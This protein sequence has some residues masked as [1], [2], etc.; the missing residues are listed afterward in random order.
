[1]TY[2]WWLALGL[3]LLTFALAVAL[4]R[5]WGELSALKKRFAPIVYVD[6]ER[7]RVKAETEELEKEVAR[8]RRDW[9]TEFK[10]TIAELETLTSELDQ[11]R[12]LVEMQ[13]FGV[14]EPQFDFDTPERYK[15]KIREIRDEQKR[16]VRDKSA[17]ICQIEW[18]VDGSKAKGRTMTNRHLRLMLRA[19]NGEC[20]AA[21][22]KARYSNVVAL[23]GRMERART[24]INKLGETNKCLIA[25][26]YF[27]LK[28]DELHAAYEYRQKQQEAKEEQRRIREEMREE[29]RARREIEK[30]VRD[31]ERDEARYNKALEQARDEMRSA[32]EAKQTKLQAKIE[33]L[34]RRL[35]EAQQNRER[36][37]SRAEMTKS[38]HVYVISNLGSFGESVF[39]IGMTRRLDPIDRVKELG[40]A[41]VPF[42]FDVHAMIYSENAPAL[43]NSLHKQFDERRLNLANSRKEFFQVEIDE[44]EDAVRDFGASVEFTKAAE[45]PE[46]RQ[47]MSLLARQA[48]A[49]RQE[50]APLKKA[51]DLL[52]KRMRF[53]QT[54]VANIAP[55]EHN[56]VD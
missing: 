39:K 29:E 38:G 52:E 25:D 48:R 13:S 49:A 2:P 50:D 23:E 33:E 30:A 14:Y 15:T 44:I 17:A 24:A 54:Q 55:P 9:E 32:N 4:V 8:R 10:E 31:A 1:M 43:E 20:D 21:I 37:K 16:M 19:F 46:F 56:A 7:D 3:P 12:D 27:R 26:R 18:Q 53:W 42:G 36:A 11:T 40:D 5:V 22:A 34:E 35:D 6:E 45:A 41:S 47:T 51:K 28:L